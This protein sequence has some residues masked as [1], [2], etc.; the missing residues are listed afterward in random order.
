MLA[1]AHEFQCL[2][3]IAVY[4]AVYIAV[5][6]QHMLRYQ[7]C[8]ISV[9]WMSAVVAMVVLAL[10]HQFPVDALTSVNQD[11]LTALNKVDNVP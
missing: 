10:P 9:T 8:N 2:R 11:A 7:E 1:S 3:C 5:I 4:N 6:R